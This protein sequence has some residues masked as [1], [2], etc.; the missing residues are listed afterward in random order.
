[1]DKLSYTWNIVL[2]GLWNRAILT[3]AGM[4][5][6][7]FGLPETAKI[8]FGDPTSQNDSNAF[9]L[10]IQFAVDWILPPK[11]A[12]KNVFTSVFGDKIFFEPTADSKE[13]FESL[14]TALRY[15][16]NVL[17]K[18]PETPVSAIG[19]N[20]N[21]T[22]NE[23]HDIYDTIC[24]QCLFSDVLDEAINL[25]KST[26]DKLCTRS[27]SRAFSWGEG[28]VKVAFLKNEEESA[29]NLSFNFQRASDKP[30]QLIEW[31]NRPAEEF[32]DKADSILSRIRV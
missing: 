12:Y 2:L 31:I 27:V 28:T 22:I 1:M 10:E 18:L 3:P 21:V 20:L 26:S 15:G 9:P 29:V 16:R 24:N 30:A 13:S 11:V 5:H 25:D 8:S 32:R 4:S 23:E 7:V 6:R 17:E 14:G 19:I